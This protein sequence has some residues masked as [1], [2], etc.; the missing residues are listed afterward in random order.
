MGRIKLFEDFMKINID[1]LSYVRTR[2]EEISDLVNSTLKDFEGDSNFAY[3]L[4]EE[5]LEVNL[6]LNR[7]SVYMLLDFNTF[8]LGIYHNEEKDYRI[9]SVEEGLDII[10]KKIYSVLEIS[11]NKK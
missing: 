1:D 2:M 11:E 10:E 5:E 3:Q 6:T 8:F 4:S 7:K 9:N